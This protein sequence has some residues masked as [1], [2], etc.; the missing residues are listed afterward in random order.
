MDTANHIC[1]YKLTQ[2]Y[3]CYGCTTGKIDAWI[4]KNVYCEKDNSKFVCWSFSHEIAL[5]DF[6]GLFKPSHIYTY[7]KKLTVSSCSK[8][9]FRRIPARH[10]TKN[11]MHKNVAQRAI[12]INWPN[13]S[14]ESIILRLWGKNWT[15]KIAASAIAKRLEKKVENFYCIKLWSWKHAVKT[16]KNIFMYTFQ[17]FQLFILAS[18]GCSPTLT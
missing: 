16:V 8:W 15:G 7:N 2:N 5:L 11:S 13:R 18:I 1:T 14:N 6:I 4:K 17:L 9:S 10:Q 3:D 12:K